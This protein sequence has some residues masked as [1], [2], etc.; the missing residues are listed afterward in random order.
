MSEDWKNRV[1]EFEVN[2]PGRT[3]EKI[4]AALNESHLDD[5]FPAILHEMEVKPPASAW[6]NIAASLGTSSPL[7]KY[8]RLTPVLRYA[9]AA[10][11]II[12]IA[13]GG[14]QFFKSGNKNNIDLPMVR[15]ETPTTTPRDNSNTSVQQ[16]EEELHN[17]QAL[18][19]SKQ[20]VASLDLTSRNRSRLNSYAYYTRPVNS[21]METVE[22]SPESTYRDLTY[23]ELP[24]G[25]VFQFQPNNNLA[26]R[27]I[28]LMTP[29]GN[30]IRMS[31]KLGDL[32]C[33]VSGEE[34]D[35]DCKSQLHKWRSK[36]ASSASHA[37]NFMDILNLVN[38]LQT[39]K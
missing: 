15:T 19:E 36:I 10:A 32:V 34:Q 29:E 14:L 25:T 13:W 16:L 12:L 31:K 35:D 37:G 11:V 6:K 1:Y 21:E 20:T 17:D 8:R 9:A 24:E 27:Y 4:T 28:M 39:L 33:C 23:S 38:S 7:T 3:W 2:P 26:N 30:I 22:A 5:Q 18:E